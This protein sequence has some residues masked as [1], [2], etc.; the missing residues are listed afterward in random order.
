MSNA[1]GSSGANASMDGYNAISGRSSSYSESS[2]QDRLFERVYECLQEAGVEIKGSGSLALDVD[3]NGNIKIIGNIENKD[4][5]AEAL[6]GDKEILSILSGGTEDKNQDNSSDNLS[7]WTQEPYDVVLDGAKKFPD[8]YSTY[9]KVYS[10]FGET[11]GGEANGSVVYGV[12]YHYGNPNLYYDT[13]ESGFQLNTGID[14]AF[15]D[16]LFENRVERDSLFNY[17]SDKLAS[18]IDG[19]NGAAGMSFSLEQINTSNTLT[20]NNYR[21]RVE[22][23]NGEEIDKLAEGILSG[24]S[25]VKNELLN[26]MQN[27]NDYHIVVDAH[28]NINEQREL[29]VHGIFASFDKNKSGLRHYSPET[30]SNKEGIAASNEMWKI[31]QNASASDL[32]KYRYNTKT[33]ELNDIGEK[34]GPEGNEIIDSVHVG[35]VVKTKLTSTSLKNVEDVAPGTEVAIAKMVKADEDNTSSI[36]LDNGNIRDLLGLNGNSDVNTMITELLAKIDSIEDD[37]STQINDILE[38]QGIT[39]ADDENIDIGVGEDGTITVTSNE[40]GKDATARVEELE[41]ALNSDPEKAKDLADSLQNLGV[42]Q[43]ALNELSTEKKL[44]KNTAFKLFDMMPESTSKKQFSS[45]FEGIKD[46]GVIEFT[47]ETRAISLSGGKII[48]DNINETLTYLDNSIQKEIMAA[49]ENY[50]EAATDSRIPAHDMI[51]DSFEAVVDIEGKI[52]VIS[53]INGEGD[54]LGA[55]LK[56]I[57]EKFLSQDTMGSLYES[58]SQLAIEKH[59]YEHKDTDESE[60]E[61]KLTVDYQKGLSYEVVSEEADQAAEKELGDSLREISQSASSYLEEEYGFDSPVEITVDENGKLSASADSLTD[62]QTMQ[63]ESVIEMLNQT[64]AMSEGGEEGE[65]TSGNVFTGS[66]KEVF[67]EA[68][69]LKDILAKFHDKENLYKAIG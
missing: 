11:G 31:A 55:R 41:V 24:D 2:I 63:L 1:I 52:E 9:T 17:I 57:A 64:L 69:G 58:L 15:K 35:S 19:L 33:M 45:L 53:G 20:A 66:L 59:G 51:I 21:V 50:N 3:V 22:S 14:L 44:S 56:G 60:H 27:L 46:S 7:K 43:T 39:L 34:Y 26:G 40:I 6:N 25:H 29:N 54:E 62:Q 36:I 67:D 10:E 47:R 49:M 30:E 38:D 28:Y 32:K 12:S 23:A 4:E 61:V 68:S 37:I 18:K 42:N 16:S 13:D 65:S 48:N 5:V 8:Y